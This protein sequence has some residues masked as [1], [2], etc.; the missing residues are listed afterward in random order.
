M[1]KY[2][3]F[4][5]YS[6]K[7]V[8]W[9]KRIHTALENY[10]IPSGII[11]EGLDKKR[12]IGK[13]FRDDDE[14]AG[15]ISLKETLV[16]VL[17]QSESLIV[18]CSPNA[19]QSKWVEQEVLDF[20]V[21]HSTGKVFGIIIAGEPNASESKNPELECFPLTL[22]RELNNDGTLSDVATEPLAPDVRKE[23][24]NRVITRIIAGLLRVDFDDLWNRKERIRKRKLLIR[25]V[26]SSVSVFTLGLISAIAVS[27]WN[28]AI[29][30][31]DLSIAQSA[32][33][34]Q[35]EGNY[36]AAIQM[37]IRAKQRLSDY[38]AVKYIPFVNAPMDKTARTLASAWSLSGST[39]L[40]HSNGH[41]GS[42]SKITFSNDG[43]TAAT[44]AS[45]TSIFIWDTFT[46]Q[47]IKQLLSKSDF[48]ADKK[49]DFINSISFSHSG[50]FIE[51]DNTRIWDLE[52]NSTLPHNITFNFDPSMGGLDRQTG[53]SFWYGDTLYH[54]SIAIWKGSLK[55]F[56][57][58][59]YLVASRFGDE[60]TL[61]MDGQWPKLED[62]TDSP[63][64][65]VDD[66]LHKRGGLLTTL[67]NEF[68]GEYHLGT[69]GVMG[70]D[71]K[72]HFT[73]DQ[74][75]TK[76]IVQT[77]KHAYCHSDKA[78]AILY[79]HQYALMFTS[80]VSPQTF[81]LNS[82][83]IES[84]QLKTPKTDHGKNSFSNVMFR[85]D[86]Q[87]ILN[88]NKNL[89]SSIQLYQGNT[90]DFIYKWQPELKYTNINFATFGPSDSITAITEFNEV[91]AIG[92]DG[93]SRRLLNTPR[94]KGYEQLKK[95]TS[96]KA[97]TKVCLKEPSSYNDRIDRKWFD[98]SALPNTNVVNE[99]VIDESEALNDWPKIANYQLNLPKLEGI[100]DGGYF[101]E[102]EIKGAWLSPDKSFAVMNFYAKDLTGYLYIF[103]TATGE[104]IQ[105]L[106]IDDVEQL[107][108]T[109]DNQFMVIAGGGFIRKLQVD[110]F[111][112]IYNMPLLNQ[113]TVEEFSEINS[114]VINE[115]FGFILIAD[116][117]MG[118][119][120]IRDLHTGLLLVHQ[121]ISRELVAA[122]FTDN[123]K[124]FV[125]IGP[126][127]WAKYA[128]NAML[129]NT[130]IKIYSEAESCMKNKSDAR[131]T[132]PDQ[133]LHV[134]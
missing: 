102:P 79:S 72:H 57:S 99:E 87:Y 112:T 120:T 82:P 41:L 25:L 81:D 34:L 46:G 122:W 63:P 58:F 105:R 108:I 29:K 113:K 61:L 118:S 10:S 117:Q 8:K 19:T 3:A 39:L 104:Q 68:N 20:K 64:W 22:R 96:C 128:I 95:I 7:D 100:N 5:S 98:M 45:D 71:S 130:S 17:T 80:S 16:E 38:D 40:E 89:D 107:Y 48:F 66:V 131:Q 73:F 90:G 69:V 28:N 111:N 49:H 127:G 26:I 37:A 78:K 134:D 55:P 43:R 115:E 119:V 124:N 21:K 70:V 12:R 123:G 74:D 15:S 33:Q 75:N 65:K 103:D 116:S 67:V 92:F 84:K 85:N 31:R 86:C 114:L 44:I 27:N 24:F 60:S 47:P 35:R 18:I 30:T 51:A 36:K 32:V 125:A 14:L 54:P 132:C 101:R 77:S 62:L 121:F 56:D 52:T 76:N 9:A 109:S 110:V 4:I 83:N 126:F 1:F 6:Q 93:E 91:M 59:E 23:D 13:V 106:D 42:I 2:K 133:Y 97:K 53:T 129:F 94:L 88:V 50:R 11:V